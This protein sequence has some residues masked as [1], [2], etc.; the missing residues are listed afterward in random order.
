ML[1]GTNDDKVSWKPS[2]TLIR[3]K[4]RSKETHKTKKKLIRQKAAWALGAAAALS[5]VQFASA[6]GPLALGARPEHVTLADDGPIRGQVF[7]AEY[8]GTT[9]IVTLDTVHGQVKARLP[10]AV[11]VRLGENVGLKF[12]TRGLALFDA[13]SGRALRSALHEGV[14]YG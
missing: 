10:A 3:S 8:L 11:K 14:S 12:H 7:G 1:S 5:L 9:Q 13:A 6:Q 4:Q 2:R